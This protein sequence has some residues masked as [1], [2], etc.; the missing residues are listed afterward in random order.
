MAKLFLDPLYTG[1]K[2][3]VIVNLIIA[4]KILLQ[5]KT[6]Q[7]QAETILKIF[8]CGKIKTGHWWWFKVKPAVPI[9]MFLNHRSPWWYLSTTGQRKC[10]DK[11]T[12]FQLPISAEQKMTSQ[13]QGA[14][15][16]L[17]IGK[18]NTTDMFPHLCGWQQLVCRNTALL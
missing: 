15:K 7:L 14:N 17:V 3:S 9:T 10:E 1:F 18:C 4:L 12:Q 5:N 8:W 11:V 2:R 6:W 13:G 16:T